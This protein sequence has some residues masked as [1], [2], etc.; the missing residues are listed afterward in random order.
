MRNPGRKGS[1]SR[2]A[3]GLETYRVHAFGERVPAHVVSGAV[4]RWSDCSLRELASR[5]GVD[6]GALA[7]VVRQE[8]PYCRV[9]FADAVLTTLGVPWVLDD[10][11]E[12]PE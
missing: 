5:A 8:R 2:A 4:R 1:W 6:F 11:S 3:A 9:A 12:V 10:I 7:R